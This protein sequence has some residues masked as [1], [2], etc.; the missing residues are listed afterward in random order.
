MVNKKREKAF[1]FSGTC[2]MIDLD[3]ATY[4]AWRGSYGD[5]DDITGTGSFSVQPDRV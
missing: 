4:F 5:S 3:F 1:P 2:S